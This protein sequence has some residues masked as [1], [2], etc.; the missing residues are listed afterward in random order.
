[1]PLHDLVPTTTKDPE[2]EQEQVDKIQIERECTENRPFPGHHTIQ[3]GWLRHGHIF[4]LLSIIGSQAH[5]DDH[6]DVTDYHAQSA[7]ANE[8]VDQ[9]GDD[10]SNRP[11]KRNEPQDIRSFL[12]VQP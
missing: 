2:Q 1:M 11:M 6:A 8:Y 7:A 3:P 12:V 4:Q 5:E 10:D 9:R